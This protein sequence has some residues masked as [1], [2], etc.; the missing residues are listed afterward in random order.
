MMQAVAALNDV[1][2]ASALEAV[3]LF[4]SLAPHELDALC[5]AAPPRVFAGGDPI[6]R[7][8]DPSVSCFAVVSGEVEVT[9]GGRKGTPVQ[10][11]RL[12]PADLFGEL[13]V[14]LGRNRTASVS[15]A[16]PATLL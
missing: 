12:G 8:G 7:E 1:D 15:A 13:G 14:L 5:G 10:I 11:R 3:P 6:L 2:V 4:S 16:R 9:A